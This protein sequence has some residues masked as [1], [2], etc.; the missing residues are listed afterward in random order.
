MTLREAQGREARVELAAMIRIKETTMGNPPGDGM[1]E[2]AAAVSVQDDYSRRVQAV[3][4]DAARDIAAVTQMYLKREM[5]ASRWMQLMAI[6]FAG[7]APDEFLAER[8]QAGTRA[9]M[10][11]WTKRAHSICEHWRHTPLSLEQALT[12]ALAKVHA[13]GKAEGIAECQAP[14]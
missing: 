13:E 4:D 14:S 6:H 11:N 5:E 9:E 2:K 1:E 8:A 7:V 12:Q 3:T 10:T